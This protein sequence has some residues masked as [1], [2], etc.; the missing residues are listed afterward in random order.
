MNALHRLGRI[1]LGNRN[2]EKLTLPMTSISTLE[3]PN[4]RRVHTMG[5]VHPGNIPATTKNK[6]ID[7]VTDEVFSEGDEVDPADAFEGNNAYKMVLPNYESENFSFDS[8][9][10]ILQ[11]REDEIK[12]F[13]EIIKPK[14][15]DLDKI[16]SLKF[17][18]V[19]RDI[20]RHMPREFEISSDQSE[21][22]Y[23]ERLLPLRIVPPLPPAPNKD[24]TYPSGFCAPSRK[25]G[26]LAYHVTRTRSHMLPVY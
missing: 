15:D 12:H 4:I 1:I 16:H 20:D 8:D 14:R 9:T 17:G 10:G 2:V 6:T 25:P 24:G 7:T 11:E 22:D 3:K 5:G 21:W 19:A 13:E 26:N 23:V 18:D